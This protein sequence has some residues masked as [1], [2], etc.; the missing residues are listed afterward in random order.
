M[1]FILGKKSISLILLLT[2]VILSFLYSLSYVES[3]TL[4]VTQRIQMKAI[5]D[6]RI[7]YLINE[8]TIE[9]YNPYNFTII[10]IYGNQSVILYPGESVFFHYIPNLNTIEIETNN[11]KEII[12]I[13]HGDYP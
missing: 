6:P 8:S 12:Y 9:V 7:A 10:V 13:P 3:L 2:I 4:I 1:V 11:F 5:I